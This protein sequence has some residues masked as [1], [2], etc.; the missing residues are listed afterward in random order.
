M[1]GPKYLLCP[2]WVTSQTDGQRHFV[3]ERQLAALYSV[4]MSQCAVRGRFGWRLIAGAIELHPRYDG[5]YTLPIPSQG[6]KEDA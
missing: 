3:G 5:N 1:S 4:P 2:G 6:G